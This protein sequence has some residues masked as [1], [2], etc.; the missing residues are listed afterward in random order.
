MGGLSHLIHNA[1]NTEV[2]QVKALMGKGLGLTKDGTHV[3]FVGGTGVLVFIDLV[4]LLL[5]FNLG[6]ITPES[7]PIFA[8]GSTFK[9]VLY[10]S[11]P[12]REEALGIELLEGLRDVTQKKGLNNFELV[13][14]IKN[15]GPQGQS[16]WDQDYISR[17]IEIRQKENLTK[18]YVCG[19]PVMGELFDR[20]FDS[21]INRRSLRS[22][23][24]HV[25]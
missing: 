7:V 17:Q 12:N 10:A 16:R 1:L 18:A 14:R 20:V 23:Q 3:A 19:P 4:A 13:L 8:K 2:F 24:V 21:M 6:L 22:S 25:M 15:E 9:F 5:R 11:F